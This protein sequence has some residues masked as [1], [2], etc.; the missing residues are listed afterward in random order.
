MR[1]PTHFSPVHTMRIV[2]LAL[3]G[4]GACTSAA[5]TA[6]PSAARTQT[7]AILGSPVTVSLRARV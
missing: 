4:A 1:E 6:D 5:A 7:I 3:L 2:F